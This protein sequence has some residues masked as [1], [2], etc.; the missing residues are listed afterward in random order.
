MACKRVSSGLRRFVLF[1][2]LRKRKIDFT[3]C[4]GVTFLFLS[5][6]ITFLN[7]SIPAFL[8]SDFNSSALLMLSILSYNSTIEECL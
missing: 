2:M 5:L 8:K 7:Y 3:I 1:K 4:C 6:W